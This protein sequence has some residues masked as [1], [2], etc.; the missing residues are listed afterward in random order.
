MFSINLKVL[1]ATV[2][3]VCIHSISAKT[4]NACYASVICILHISA[5]FEKSK[6]Q[7]FS[8]NFFFS[9]LI[10]CCF[11]SLHQFHLVILEGFS[12]IV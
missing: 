11:D 8:N 12:P 2:T 9:N 4:C 3:E 7:F 5:N 6:T 10:R 1:V